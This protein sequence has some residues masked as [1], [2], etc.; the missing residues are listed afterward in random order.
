MKLSRIRNLLFA[1]ACVAILIFFLCAS[2]MGQ[3]TENENTW[4]VFIVCMTAAQLCLAGG[5]VLW[6]VDRLRK[7]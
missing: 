2:F 4:R 1:A 7:R 5:I 6:I 3:Q